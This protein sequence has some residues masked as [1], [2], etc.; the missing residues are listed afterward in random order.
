V[1]AVR[2]A[3]GSPDRRVLG[4]RERAVHTAGLWRRLRRFWDVQVSPGAWRHVVEAI[5]GCL[6][7]PNFPFREWFVAIYP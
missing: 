1:P 4:L 6:G 5:Y 2:L 7:L 3:S